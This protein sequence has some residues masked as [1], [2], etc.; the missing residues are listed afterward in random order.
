MM[1]LIWH[2]DFNSNEKINI[3]INY[4]DMSFVNGAL[5]RRAF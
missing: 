2:H 4:I 3:C 1:F 5:F